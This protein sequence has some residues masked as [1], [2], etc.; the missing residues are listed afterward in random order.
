MQLNILP[1][2]I[3]LN[4]NPGNCALTPGLPKFWCKYFSQNV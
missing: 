1:L 3:I 4:R 2:Q